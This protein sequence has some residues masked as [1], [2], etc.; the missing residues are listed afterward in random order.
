MPLFV[1][2]DN[3][4]STHN[5]GAI[6]RSCDAIMASKIFLC[7]ITAHPPRADIAK[8]ALGA[9]QTVPWEYV[10]TTQEA[11]LK[12]KENG[13]KICE[14]E[15]AEG[16]QHYKEARYDFPVALVLGSEVDGVSEECMGL[17]DMCVQ[18]PMLGRANSLNVATAFGIV[19]Y[20]ILW[21]YG[22]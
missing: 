6:F 16:S 17:L 12:L 20:E 4:R 9:D 13:V 7:G 3:V 10:S 22:K 14:L 18:I 5:V 8:A 21:Q 11:L 19:G 1:V 15:L 2:L